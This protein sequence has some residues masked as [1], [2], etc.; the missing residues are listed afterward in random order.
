MKFHS[1]LVASILAGTVVLSNVLTFNVKA[2]TKDLEVHFIN[3]GQGDATYIELLNG[4]DILIDAGDVGYGQRVVNYLKNEEND[5]D[6]EY[7][8]ATH[9]DSD[10]IGG[11]KDV[12]TQ[13]NVKN[14]YYPQDTS[15]S[16]N[17]WG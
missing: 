6:I 1:K 16:S 10:H 5:I 7:L 3:V 2:E 13:L 8:I 14:F 17:I 9:P 11:M 15:N 12:F 4:D